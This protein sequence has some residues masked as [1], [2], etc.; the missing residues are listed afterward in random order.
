M[1]ALITVELQL[2]GDH[3]FF[4]SFPNCTQNEVYIL[5]GASFVSN[6]AVVKQI[7][8]DREI[9]NTLLCVYV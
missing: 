3:F 9:E 8:D 4:L 5:L 7:S 2:C 6:N 1:K